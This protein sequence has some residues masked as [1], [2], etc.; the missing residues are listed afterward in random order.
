MLW[1]RWCSLSTKNHCFGLV[2]VISL[3]VIIKKLL[4]WKTLNIK[5]E[6]S[7]S[8]LKKSIKFVKNERLLQNNN[9]IRLLLS[10]I[11][12]LWC[13]TTLVWLRWWT[14]LH[15]GAILA[16]PLVIFLHL[17]VTT[18]QVHNR[19]PCVFWGTVT[20]PFNKIGWL[21]V[22]AFIFQD[23]FHFIFFVA[24]DFNVFC[25]SSVFWCRFQ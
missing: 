4:S 15:S 18:C 14:P 8:I 2:L 1:L 23:T 9:K 3:H 16:F 24:F 20:F 12:L 22:N 6:K 17:V 10:L 13:Q 19:F 25:C 11:I 7:L 5:K 21:S